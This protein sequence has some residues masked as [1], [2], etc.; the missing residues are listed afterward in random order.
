MQGSDFLAPLWDLQMSVTDLTLMHILSF[1]PTA[2]GTEGCQHTMQN[3]ILINCL[4]TWW[5]STIKLHWRGETG[6]SSWN[7]SLPSLYS[8]RMW[9]LLSGECPSPASQEEA[10]VM[11]L[12]LLLPALPWTPMSGFHSSNFIHKQLLLHGSLVLCSSGNCACSTHAAHETDPLLSTLLLQISFSQGWA[13]IQ[14]AKENLEN[15]NHV[16]LSQQNP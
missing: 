15:I 6:R 9:P 3:V 16:S 4:M 7:C 8:S 11:L 1:K 12:C 13:S 14:N 10:G 5:L 2:P